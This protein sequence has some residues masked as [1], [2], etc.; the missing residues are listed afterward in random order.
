M[1]ALWPHNYPNR[2]IYGGCVCSCL[3]LGENVQ[4]WKLL[5]QVS[6]VNKSFPSNY[7]LRYFNI[8]KVQF[9]YLWKLGVFAKS[10]RGQWQDLSHFSITVYIFPI[11]AAWYF[12]INSLPCPLMCQLQQEWNKSQISVGRPRQ[13]CHKP[14]HS[15]TTLNKSLSAANHVSVRSSAAF[16]ALRLS[17]EKMAPDIKSQL[18]SAKNLKLDIFVLMD[19]LFH[20]LCY[21]EDSCRVQP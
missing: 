20:C 6:A 11:I 3:C 9:F 2:V 17:E 16:G 13:P 19:G 1:T 4:C 12:P 7:W 5:E 10:H 14:H 8:A 18:L 15:G 21:V